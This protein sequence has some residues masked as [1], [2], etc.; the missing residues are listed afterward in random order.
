ME[1][2]E[3]KNN[4][5][6]FENEE[7]FVNDY[8][9]LDLETTGL[10][11]NKNEIVEIVAIKVKNYKVLEVYNKLIKPDNDISEFITSISIENISYAR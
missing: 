2:K 8:V 10:N 5:S 1:F 9:V 3:N 4:K 7:E 6:F 11:P